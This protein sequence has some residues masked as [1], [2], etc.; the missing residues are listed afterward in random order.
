MFSKLW[1]PWETRCTPHSRFKAPS[2][3]PPTVCKCSLIQLPD[4]ALI[5]APAQEPSVT[6]SFLL[7]QVQR[8]QPTVPSL[9]PFLGPGTGLPLFLTSLLQN[10]PFSCPLSFQF[11]FPGLVHSLVHYFQSPRPSQVPIPALSSLSL[12]PC[13]PSVPLACSFFLLVFY[14]THARSEARYPLTPL[15]CS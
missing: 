10:S 11:P 12:S 7:G 5:H 6:P 3:T 4:A 14:L 15:F 13:Y 9:L 2:S 8:P 1:C